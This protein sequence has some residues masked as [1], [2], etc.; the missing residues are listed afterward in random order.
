[1]HN[2]S[3]YPAPDYS[4]TR[5]VVDE[6]PH[7]VSLPEEKF[8]TILFLPER[9]GRLG[10]GG[11]RT[12]GYFKRSYDD[13][14]L[15]SVI[16]VVFN[17]EQHLEETILS[18]IKQNYDNVE[19]IIV[20]GGSTDGTLEIIKRY[21]DQIDYWVSEPDSGVYDAMNKGIRLAAGE[22]INLMNCGDVFSDGS[23]LKT[24]FSEKFDP[25]IHLLYGEAITE[26]KQ[27]NITKVIGKELDSIEDFYYGMPLCHQAVF[28][29]RQAFKKYGLFDLK[30]KIAA[31][32]VWL[33]MF[34]DEAFE[35][36]Q[37]IDQV[38]ANYEHGGFASD[39]L[40]Y[41][42]KEEYMFS[43]NFFPLRVTMRKFLDFIGIKTKS[44]FIGISKK[45]KIYMLYVKVKKKLRH[46]I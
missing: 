32:Y 24:V 26:N 41:A 18:V 30:Y 15:V 5:L 46:K 45:M 11:L 19:Y 25:K 43:K 9:E 44:L 31:D 7:F 1:M 39:N 34:F 42:K 17:G 21:E 40:S 36:A 10:E 22:W 23:L 28:H 33:C 38:I 37:Y 12:K 29:R 13:R 27:F 35:N 2:E 16:T 3:I 20:D 6:K 14:P 8:E 4:T